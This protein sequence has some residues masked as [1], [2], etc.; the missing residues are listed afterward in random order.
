MKLWLHQ[1]AELTQI[2]LESVCPLCGRSAAAVL[3]PNCQQQLQRARL[4]APDQLWQPPLP[5]F[6]WG[7]YGGS[8]KR[9][10]TLLKYDGQIQLAKPLGQAL[11][12]AWLASSRSVQPTR[13]LAV[14]PIP[15]HLEKQRQRGFNQA[16]LIA[17]AFCQQTGLPLVQGL[18]R[19]RQ[20]TPQFGLSATERSENLAEAF[21]LGAGLS[22]RSTQRPAV[23][24]LD[25]IY[26]TGATALAAAQTLRRHQISVCG[27]LAVA[28]AGDDS[29]PR[30]EPKL[31]PKLKKA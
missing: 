24:L 7:Q 25:D 19:Q 14:V 11:A 30:L 3:C 13:R 23:L 4:P 18:S 31:E 5:I 16:E 28:K 6:A 12:Q 29:E 8:L 22:H 20:T 21:A 26:T 2:C 17:R 15:M 10:L 1:L 27:I 9:A